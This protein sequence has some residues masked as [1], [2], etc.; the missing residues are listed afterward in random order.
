MASGLDE[1]TSVSVPQMAVPQRVVTQHDD[2]LPRGRNTTLVI[3]KARYSANGM[4][5]R[6]QETI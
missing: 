4:M 1:E 3:V 2:G 6:A 5:D